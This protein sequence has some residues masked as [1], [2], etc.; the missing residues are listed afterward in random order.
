MLYFVDSCAHL[1][2]Q[3]LRL[4]VDVGF[5]LRLYPAEVCGQ[6]VVC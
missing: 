4:N 2:E 5:G 3:F 6:A 1:H